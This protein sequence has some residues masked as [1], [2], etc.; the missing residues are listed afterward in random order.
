MPLT[1]ADVHETAMNLDGASVGISWNTRTWMVNRR[2]FA[3]ERPLRKADI[4]R[5][6]GT[7]A[8]TGEI[9]GVRTESL[10][11]KDALLAMGLPGFFTIEHFNAYPAVL[12]ALDKA[13]AAD[14]RAAIVE[15]H[16]AVAAMR[17]GRAK[18]TP[19]ANK[20]PTANKKPPANKKPAAKKT[21][22]G[23]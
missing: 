10:D 8:P 9:L 13:R 4:A 3:W 11:A 14:V 15:A 7:P 5:L 12:I 16:R 1:F 6:G 2:G 21:G 17:P 19:A 18:K 20:K 22:R 23:R